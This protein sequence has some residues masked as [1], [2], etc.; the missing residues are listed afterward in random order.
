M[1]SKDGLTLVTGSGSRPYAGV[2]SYAYGNAQSL[3][4][5]VARVGLADIMT[6]QI[7]TLVGRPLRRLVDYVH[8][9]REL[10][11]PT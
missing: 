11:Q 6:D 8:D 10:W 3:T 5:V 4:N 9:N 1:A 2:Q 7:S